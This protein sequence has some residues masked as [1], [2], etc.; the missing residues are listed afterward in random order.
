MAATGERPTQV[1]VKPVRLGTIS[2]EPALVD[3]YADT[4]ERYRTLYPLVKGVTR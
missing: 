2:P 3:A 4:Y 1:C